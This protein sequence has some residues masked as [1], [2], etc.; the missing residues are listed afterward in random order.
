MHM[1][2]TVK[3]EVINPDSVELGTPKTGKIKVYFDASD[4]SDAEKR[5]TN[6]VAILNIG[7]ALLITEGEQ[8][9]G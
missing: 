3:T 9:N 7:K 8:N 1:S 2:E 6:A 4:M 5:V